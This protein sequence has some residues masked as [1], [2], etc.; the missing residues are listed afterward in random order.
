VAADSVEA[1]GEAVAAGHE[2]SRSGRA[3]GT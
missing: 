3:K 2:S 1:E